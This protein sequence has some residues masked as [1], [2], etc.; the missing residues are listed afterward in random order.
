MIWD[1]TSRARVRL[2]SSSAS[3]APVWMRSTRRNRPNA[4]I[5]R[6]VISNRT[7][8]NNP[9]RPTAIKPKT[10]ERSS[11]PIMKS[12]A[13]TPIRKLMSETRRPQNQRARRF[14]PFAAKLATRC[15]A[16]GVGMTSSSGTGSAV[17]GVKSSV[18]S[19]SKRTGP[20]LAFCVIAY[21]PI[22]TVQRDQVVYA[23]AHPRV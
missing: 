13:A 20:F 2:W 8:Q 6:K 1:V 14:G 19:R 22:E 21:P 17:D 16:A 10:G 12:Q 18:P 5:S 7:P 15:M 11:K 9:V 3:V 23:A 4:A